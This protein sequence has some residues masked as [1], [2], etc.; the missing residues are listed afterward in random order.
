MIPVTCTTE[1]PLASSG[2]GQWAKVPWYR[3]S[4]TI[5]LAAGRFVVIPVVGGLL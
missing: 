3:R 2:H 4:R 5:R 1:F